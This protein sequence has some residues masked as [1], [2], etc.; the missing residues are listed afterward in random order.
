MYIYGLFIHF[1][2]ISWKPSRFKEKK[3][4]KS[5]LWDTI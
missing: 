4:I 5:I 3:A 2:W 1:D